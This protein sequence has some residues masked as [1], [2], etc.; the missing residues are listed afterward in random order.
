[1]PAKNGMPSQTRLTKKS[2]GSWLARAATRIAAYR[3]TSTAS[4]WVALA[5]MTRQY[6]HHDL[7]ARVDALQPA[8][9]AR[10]PLREHRAF[11]RRRD[12]GERVL[13]PADV[14]FGVPRWPVMRSPRPALGNLAG[15]TPPKE[16]RA[17][18]PESPVPAPSMPTSPAIS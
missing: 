6:E 7:G 10:Q 2:N 9:R 12:A 4:E 14:A 17:E 8:R 11:D 13:E 1:M 18:A 15:I 5:A 16:Q 3:P